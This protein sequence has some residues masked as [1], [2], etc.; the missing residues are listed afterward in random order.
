MGYLAVKRRA[1]DFLCL[2]P[3]VHVHY[4]QASTSAEFYNSLAL[5]ETCN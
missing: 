4:E 5:G 3:E 2:P 1:H